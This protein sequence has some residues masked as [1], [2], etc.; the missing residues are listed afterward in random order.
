MFKEVGIPVVLFGVLWTALNLS[1]GIAA[2]YS[3]RF[4]RWLGTPA[5]LWL[6]SLGIPAG[7]LLT[8]LFPVIWALGFLFVFYL[9]RGIATPVLKEYINLLCS[10]DVRATV[11]SIRN[12]VIRLLFAVLGPFFGWLTDHLSLGRALL[13]AGLIFLAGMLTSQLFYLRESRKQ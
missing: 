13:I 4:S 5:T 10:S 1:V 7:F 11:L 3:Y 6:F 12:F 2:I 9:I 8:G